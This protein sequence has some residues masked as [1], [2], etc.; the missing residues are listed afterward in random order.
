[1]RCAVRIPGGDHYDA[2]AGK[3][4]FFYSVTHFRLLMIE[5]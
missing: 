3:V 2:L 4:L 5:N 1:L